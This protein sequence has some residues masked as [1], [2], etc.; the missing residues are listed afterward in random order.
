M[1]TRAATPRW[2]S[3]IRTATCMSAVQPSRSISR[4]RRAERSRSHPG[5]TSNGVI[6]GYI[7]RLS[8]D[9]AA[10]SAGSLHF[11]AATYTAADT[12]GNAIVTVTRTG[13][14]AGAVSA[15]FATS[16]GTGKAGT[17]YTATTQTVN[18][19]AG[20]T[21]A[22]TISVPV[23]VNSTVAGN[24]TVNLTLS[25]PT[26]GATLGSPTTAVLTITQ[27]TPPSAGAL[28]FSAGTFSA[29]DTAGSASI[30]VTRVGGSNGAVAASFATSDGTG[31]A[32]TDYTAT[33]Q[34]VNFAAGDTAAKT[35]SV[36]VKVNS[37]V[38]GNETVNLTLSSPTGSASLGSPAT[39]VL[40]ITQTTAPITQ[41]TVAG[42]GGG[43]AT[44][45]FELVL[46]GLIALARPISW[47]KPRR[48]L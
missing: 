40:T 25:S 29:A 48:H 46:L 27:T 3:A 35:V 28:Q 6:S 42:K 39:A 7:A 34:T 15:S 9:L 22:K 37:T 13:G 24:E 32:G 38:A 31:K 17:D 16:D 5:A 11:S 19:A 33:T 2:P 45:S 1:A 18:F 20:D 4:A 26:G 36:P 21:A 10:L 12:S 30:T 23:K 43:G 14:S 8:A 41:V 44:G 47:R